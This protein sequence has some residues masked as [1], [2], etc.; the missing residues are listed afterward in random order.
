MSGVI[1]VSIHKNVSELISYSN[2]KRHRKTEEEIRRTARLY[3]FKKTNRFSKDLHYVFE[4]VYSNYVRV[5]SNYLFVRLGTNM[6][7]N[8]ESIGQM[9]YLDYVMNTSVDTVTAVFN[10]APMKGSCLLNIKNDFAFMCID[11][12][13]G[14]SFENN[15]LTRDFT[16]IE[17]Q[18]LKIVANFF[19]EPQQSCWNEF[20]TVE[21]SLKALEFN[22]L[23]IQLTSDNESVLV[24]DITIEVG[25]QEYPVK[26]AFPYVSL[27]NI[28]DQLVIHNNRD[29]IALDPDEHSTSVIKSHIIQSDVDINVVLG[30][31]NV[32]LA[33]ISNLK[34]GDVISL[35][36]KF[37][38]LLPLQIEG[39]T[40]FYVQPG[41]NKN[42]L[43]VQVVEIENLE[44]EEGVN[45]HE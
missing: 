43:A 3:D 14:G 5:L 32:P 12:I 25:G 44:I 19:I 41:M 29:Q 9:T 15:P 26:L 33:Y 39:K 11:N 30:Q 20:L 42:K 1:V 45:R 17:K 34:V 35:D 31:K 10:L 18:L 27:E 16:A 22:P 23:V 21:P 7:L 36:C 2:T 8:L 40:H 6:K 38:D 4:C 37:N 28:V 24:V 13:C